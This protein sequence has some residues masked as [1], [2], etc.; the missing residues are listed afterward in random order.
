MYLVNLLLVLQH[1]GV[2][3]DE[4]LA[5][6]AL[7]EAFVGLLAL[8]LNLLLDL[9]DMVLNE[10]VGAVA[11]LA[12]LV[13]DEGVVECV[14]MAAGLP[15]AGM[16]EDGAVEAHDVLVHLHHGLPPG[17]FDVVF[18][19]DAELTVVVDSGEAII[20]FRTGEDETVFFGVSHHFL[21]KFVLICHI[22][23]V[24]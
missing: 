5:V 21:E 12:V 19:F 17:L 4:L 2:G 14:H 23:C 22:F 20:D 10:D 15:D 13:V 18:Q 6:E 7:A 11:L 3:G 1:A 8:L 24:F 9:G 16:H